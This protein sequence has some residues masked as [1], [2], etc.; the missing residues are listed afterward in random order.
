MSATPLLQFPMNIDTVVSVVRRALETVGM[1]DSLRHRAERHG[2]WHE[3]V[4]AGRRAEDAAWIVI[5]VAPQQ[6]VVMEILARP[7]TPAAA[8][9]CLYETAVINA[10]ELYH[11]TCRLVL[12]CLNAANDQPC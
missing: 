1:P 11:Q 4:L 5:T 8:P 10:D 3:L 6:P 2:L 12:L 7:H 9:Q